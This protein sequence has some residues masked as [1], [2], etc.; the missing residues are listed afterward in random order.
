VSILEAI[1]LGVIQGATEFLPISSS[2]HLILIPSVLNLSEPDLNVIAIAHL[3]TLLAV[4]VYFRL[5]ILN[6]VKAVLY[7]LRVRQPLGTHQARLGWYIVAGT[8]PVAL[9]GL[10]FNGLIDSVLG[11]PAMAA[12][13]LITTG[14]ILIIGELI[15]TETRS[16]NEI[17]LSDT[18]IIA[19][20][21]VLALLPGI[22][23]SGVT[24]SAGLGR[25][26]DRRSAA[27]FSF[28]L[29]VPAIAGA[30]IFALV[31]LSHSPASA[32]QAP[33]LLATF[34]SAAIVGY[35]CIHF[36][37]EWLRNRNFYPFAAYC[38]ALAGLVLLISRP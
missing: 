1:F 21:Q 38:F 5:D 6:I 27:R 37:M 28:L 23:R 11:R 14:V 33:Q 29:G 32:A 4:L 34:L 18:M 12:L 36:L 26:F 24:I 15:L 3:G 13:L 10:L 20:A 7:G 31:D 8:I 17:N 16:L 9:A 22:S 2:G 30:A 35:L 25:G 19:L